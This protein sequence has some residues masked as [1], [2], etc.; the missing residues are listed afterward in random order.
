MWPLIQ[1]LTFSQ[2]SDMLFLILA[3][4]VAPVAD[5]S[6]PGKHWKLLK[7]GNGSISNSTEVQFTLVYVFFMKWYFFTI[8][9]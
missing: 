2:I 6:V 3:W 1:G 8:K 9:F 5:P 7:F 4:L